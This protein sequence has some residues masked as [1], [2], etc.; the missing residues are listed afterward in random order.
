M[1]LRDGTVQRTFQEMGRKKPFTGSKHR[2]GEKIDPAFSFLRPDS[3]Y[4]Y[5]AT[6][7]GLNSMRCLYP[8]GSIKETVLLPDK[9]LGSKAKIQKLRSRSE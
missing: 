7:A 5:N 4:Y 1:L 3:Y 2:L 9:N 6:T 8:K